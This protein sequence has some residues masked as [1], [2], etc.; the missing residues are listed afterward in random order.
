MTDFYY[1]FNISGS[2]MSNTTYLA[3][4]F[5]S[6]EMQNGAAVLY[7]TSTAS[8]YLSFS[9]SFQGQLPPGRF[10]IGL[11]VTG[12]GNIAGTLSCS[13]AVNVPI[14]GQLTAFGQILGTVTLQA[15]QT[16]VPFNFQGEGAQKQDA[17]KS[18][19]A[20]VEKPD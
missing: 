18:L 19:A 12:S 1:N 9:N 3:V 7:P 16:S 11:V 10:S 5:T 20:A 2:G 6:G 15:G 14:T 17:E 4:S 8:T 13:P